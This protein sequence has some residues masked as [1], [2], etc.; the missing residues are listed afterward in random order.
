MGS[1]RLFLLILFATIMVW[2]SQSLLVQRARTIHRMWRPTTQCTSFGAWLQMVQSQPG[3]SFDDHGPEVDSPMG[4]H[5]L[6]CN[7]LSSHFALGGFL[8]L[9]GV[10]QSPSRIVCYESYTDIVQG[11]FPVAPVVKSVCTTL[12]QLLGPEI[13]IGANLSHEEKERRMVDGIRRTLRQGYTI[14]MFID[15][16]Q[17]KR[18]RALNQKVLTYFPE[19]PKQVVHLLVPTQANEFRFRRF[20]ATTCLE[21]ILT[22]REQILHEDPGTF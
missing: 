19:V 15:G 14:I 22:T 8:T 2:A 20:P 5:I 10:V 12:H 17:G 4:P 6:L 3:I 11:M 1:Y 13:C 7:H 18:M 9:A 21:N 16:L